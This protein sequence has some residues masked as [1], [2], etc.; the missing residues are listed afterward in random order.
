MGGGGIPA[1]TLI[2][3][4]STI[5]PI[6]VSLSRDCKCVFNSFINGDESALRAFGRLSSIIATRGRGVLGLMRVYVEEK[7]KRWDVCWRECRSGR[8]NI[9]S[10]WWN[11]SDDGDGRGETSD[12]LP[13]LVELWL[14]SPFSR[15]KYLVQ[16][17]IS[18]SCYLK[19]GHLVL[20]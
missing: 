9:A 15:I 17:E 16:F 4:V 12:G 2:P 6:S 5:A 1:N 10:D 3:P 8:R 7:R 11:S 13:K 19:G 18:H 20:T 14:F